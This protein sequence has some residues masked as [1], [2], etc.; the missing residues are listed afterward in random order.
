VRVRRRQVVVLEREDVLELRELGCARMNLRLVVGVSDLV[1]G[2]K[3]GQNRFWFIGP[4][5]SLERGDDAVVDHA[6]RRDDHDCRVVLVGR[7]RG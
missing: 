4:M 5:R 1:T 3:I 7:S 6:A 2:G